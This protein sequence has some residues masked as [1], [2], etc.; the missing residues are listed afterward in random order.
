MT[1]VKLKQVTKFKLRTAG[2]LFTFK[3]KDSTQTKAISSV[4]P[5]GMEKHEIGK[6]KDKKK[7]GKK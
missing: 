5:P 7:T 3:A 4:I 1:I 6:S 2:R